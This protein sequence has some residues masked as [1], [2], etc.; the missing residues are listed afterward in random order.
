M[1]EVKWLAGRWHVA[2]LLRKSLLNDQHAVSVSHIHAFFPWFLLGTFSVGLNICKLS[3]SYPDTWETVILSKLEVKLNQDA[4]L[5]ILSW[6]QRQICFPDS[7]AFCSSVGNRKI[8][9]CFF[10]YF[11]FDSV[12]FYLRHLLLE[13][14][15]DKKKNYPW[16]MFFFFSLKR[17]AFTFI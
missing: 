3:F 6:S 14:S 9:L 12:E 17:K 4:K 5:C 7:N 10:F 2:E 13:N 1:H 16:K 8:F 15:D 11:V